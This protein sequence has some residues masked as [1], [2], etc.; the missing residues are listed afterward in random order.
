[1]SRVVKTI[2]LALVALA[3]V[4]LAAPPAHARVGVVFG[5]GGPV[6]VGP[7]VYYGPP[8]V[9]PPAYYAPPPAYYPPPTTYMQRPDVQ[10]SPQAASNC[11]AGA[12][13]CP[14][15]RPLAVGA[16]CSCPTEK[17]RINGVVQ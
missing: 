1:M 16:A 7:P 12:Y 13:Q 6:F 11:D 8:V 17:G 3:G 15:P 10:A 5:F 4:A 14:I 2:A 9:Y